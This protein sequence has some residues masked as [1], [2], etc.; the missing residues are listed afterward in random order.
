MEARKLTDGINVNARAVI[1][2]GYLSNFY[3]LTHNIIDLNVCYWYNC[4]LPV[5]T[6]NNDFFIPLTTQDTYTIDVH[7]MFSASDEICDNSINSNNLTIQYDYL[8]S[9]KLSLNDAFKFYPN[10]TSGIVYFVTLDANIN[11]VAIYDVS[12]KKVKIRKY[13][14]DQKLDLS[15]LQDGIYFAILKTD[16]GVL[17]KKK[18]YFRNKFL[19]FFQTKSFRNENRTFLIDI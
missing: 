18:Y 14:G 10:P 17:N 9:E 3:K 11:E 4:T 2:N 12:R 16:I 5:L 7:I 8:S 1:G 6:F 19:K 13:L 15:E